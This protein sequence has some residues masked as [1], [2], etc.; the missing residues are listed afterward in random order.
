M[1]SS[2]FIKIN[3]MTIIT[4]SSYI[5]KKNSDCTIC[6][7]S[8]NSDSIY[9]TKK[10]IKSNISTGLCGHMFHEECITLWLSTQNKCPI[11][12]VCYK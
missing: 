7:L 1:S 5:T 4:S 12:L 8:I 11:C 3:D 9:S 2:N 6:R 10:G